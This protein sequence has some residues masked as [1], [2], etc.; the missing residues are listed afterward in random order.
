MEQ[1]RRRQPPERRTGLEP[2]EDGLRTQVGRSLQ[3][4]G[5]CGGGPSGGQTECGES[6]RVEVGPVFEYAERTGGLW[7]GTESRLPVG[8]T[9]RV[10]EFESPR[11][12]FDEDKE[13]VVRV[14][15]VTY[16]LHGASVPAEV[17][18]D[19]VS[20]GGRGGEGA[21]DGLVMLLP[22]YQVV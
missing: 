13:G 10:G 9:I 19:Q 4:N 8:A 7:Q 11:N 17:V 14:A 18:I 3:W 15:G 21:I 1:E 16:S 6:I 22:S 5:R 12:I 20:E 2:A